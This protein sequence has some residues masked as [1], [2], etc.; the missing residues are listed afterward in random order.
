ML[1]VTWLSLALLAYT[2]ALWLPGLFLLWRVPRC[3]AADRSGAADRRMGAVAAVDA[4]SRGRVE[5]AKTRSVS[6]VVPARNEERRIAPLLVSLAREARPPHEIIVVDDGSSDGTAALAR[7]QGARVIEAPPMPGG[8]T[9][10]SWACWIG[11]GA[12]S[13]DILLFLD[14]DTRLEEGGLASLLATL[15]Q[16]GGIV[17]VQPWHE[18]PRA[19]EKMSAV[20]NLV[21][22][23]ALGAFTPLGD[24]LR[25]AGAFGPCIMAS[26]EDYFRCGGHRAVSGSVMEDMALGA[27]AD[28]VG[29]RVSRLAGFGVLT[30]RMYPEGLRSMVEGWSKGLASGANDSP[31]LPRMLTSA[32]VTGTSTAALMPLVATAWALAGR[33]AAGALVAAAAVAYALYAAQVHW[34]L[35][36]IGG[37]GGWVAAAFPAPLAFFHFAFFRSLWLTKVRRHATWRGREIAFG[38]HVSRP[39]RKP[40]CRARPVAA[41]RSRRRR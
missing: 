26:R 22:M 15:E 3:R 35:R 29:V 21:V 39:C 5:S 23:A 11:A 9:G 16:R 31:L 6:V 4:G 32:W 17:S 25:A 20:C 28:A 14:A 40:F 13:G 38:I 37:F 1:P 7:S 27:A 10:K 34:M 8:W 41:D 33:P 36:R 24:R 12:A 18:A 30:F 19:Y 2:I